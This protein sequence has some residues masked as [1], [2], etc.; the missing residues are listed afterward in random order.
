MIKTQGN[1]A[2]FSRWTWC[3]G[4]QVWCPLCNPAVRMCCGLPCPVGFHCWP[5]L[6]RLVFMWSKW[7]TCLPVLYFCWRKEWRQMWKDWLKTTKHIYSGPSG[8]WNT[9]VHFRTSWASEN[10]HL[11]FFIWALC[12][13]DAK[14]KYMTGLASCVA[15]IVQ[16][17]SLW[18]KDTWCLAWVFLMLELFWAKCKKKKIVRNK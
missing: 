1:A 5:L 8:S 17:E 6:A 13:F 11:L 14:F 7:Q 18:R 2:S 16:N 12:D 3:W 15:F 4:V 10:L 9:H